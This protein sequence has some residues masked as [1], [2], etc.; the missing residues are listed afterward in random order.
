M[1]VKGL[2]IKTLKSCRKRGWAAFE[3]GI[4]RPVPQKADSQMHLWYL[5]YRSRVQLP[6]QLL[7]EPFAR[8]AVGYSTGDITAYE[9]LPTADPIKVLG[10]YPHAAMA[11]PSREQQQA[12][13]DELF[14]LY[15]AVIDAFA[16]NAKVGQREKVARFGA[17]FDLTMPP[18]MGA[19]YRALNPTFFD[20]MQQAIGSG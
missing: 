11:S 9:P 6:Y 15:P 16:G 13:W 4:S 19:Y 12:T 7:Y 20:W 5:L 10:R 8:V 2:G 18:Y 1:D 17:L 14:N 3:T